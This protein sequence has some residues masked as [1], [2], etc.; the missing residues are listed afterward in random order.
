[1]KARQAGAVGLIAFGV[2]IAAVA[3]L[4]VPPLFV[5]LIIGIVLILIGAVLLFQPERASK[6]EPQSPTVE[7]TP[8]QPPEDDDNTRP[9]PVV[10]EAP[11]PTPVRV[12]SQPPKSVVIIKP[13]E[14]GDD[15]TVIEGIGPKINDILHTVGIKTYQ[16]LS[17]QTPEQ[18]RH[19]MNAARFAAPFN[20]ESWPAQARLAA[21][22]Q[23]DALQ[24]LKDALHKGR[25]KED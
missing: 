17:E 4:R 5:G 19:I 13:A 9:L 15:L 12:Q 21:M 16:T 22:G 1:M 14:G 24:A 18:L 11:K 3:L 23:W 20:P 6:T 10:E 7:K 25:Q 8:S 2:L